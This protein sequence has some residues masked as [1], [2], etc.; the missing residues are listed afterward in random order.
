MV[1]KKTIFGSSVVLFFAIAAF[2]YFRPFEKH[3][4]SGLKIYWFIPDG[5]RAEPEV[6]KVFEWAKNGELPNLKRMMERGTYGYSRPV[7]PSH[8]PV[9]FATLLTGTTPAVHGV[10]DG[11]MRVAGYPLAMAARGGFSSTSK[12]VP[13]L[14][15]LLE[16]A[17][18]LVSLLS[19]PG[20]TPPELG[21]G[22]TIRGRWGGWG[23]DFAPVIFHPREDSSLAGEI[24]DNKRVFRFGPEL[25]KFAR[26]ADPSGWS[27]AAA[28]HSFSKLRE[29]TLENWGDTVHVL[30]ADTSDDKTTNY[31][32]AIFSRDK[33]SELAR[34]R[35]GEWSEW[36][37]AK[38]LWETKTDYNIKT[39]KKTQLEQELSSISIST[40]CR[41]AVIRLGRPGEFRVRVIYDGINPYT[42]QPPELASRITKELGPM[43]DFA[44][45]YPPQ[46]VYFREDKAIFE[47]EAELSLDWHRSAVPFLIRSLGSEAVIHSIYT[48]NQMLTSRWW[49]P[50]VDPKSPLYGSVSEEERTKLWAEV[51]GMYKKID[52]ILG[53]ILDHADANT[54][55]VFSSDH[56]AL[57]LYKEVRLNNLFAKKGWLK[58]HYNAQ[59]EAYEVDWDKTSVVFLQ[60][61]NIYVNPRGLGGNYA[62]A[63]GPAYEKLRNE[64]IEAIQGLKDSDTGIAPLGGVWRWEEAEEKIAL[65]ADR[66]G[67]LVVA[68]APP[69][70]WAE[71]MDP[72]LEVF[73]RTV[74][75]GYKQA[76]DPQNPALLTPFAMVGPGVPQGK[77]LSSPIHHVDQLATILQQLSLPP[78]SYLSGHTVLPERH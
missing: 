70:L 28:P 29:L 54:L 14:W 60:M 5:L 38:L 52:A 56:G 3:H 23:V 72:K 1:S 50:Y 57:P 41:F 61:N 47:K 78:P 19:V 64:V 76:I 34:L 10:A 27:L 15:T 62:R 24:G 6:F 36:L 59:N 31:D 13:S 71:D 63:S 20:S 12:R 68:N 9:N 58:F 74:K 65:P 45:N 25:T 8:T 77:E 46:L 2:A 7:F 42:V 55:V 16:N 30:L 48:P 26:A 67:D 75:G 17:G 21:R 37:P 22:N 49:M 40:S 32:L 44:D 69:Y 53:E 73:V 4:T 33:H 18:N 39:P 51:K 35:A 66:I 43:V 11:A